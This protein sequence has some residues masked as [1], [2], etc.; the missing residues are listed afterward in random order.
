MADLDIPIDDKLLEG[1]SRLAIRHYGDDSEVSRKRVVETALQ[2]RLLWSCS[3]RQ[4]QEETD[5]AVTEWGFAES[6]IN[7]ENTASIR[8]WLFRR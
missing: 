4:G 7:K 5:E 6:P 1:I 8:N 3:V 2:M